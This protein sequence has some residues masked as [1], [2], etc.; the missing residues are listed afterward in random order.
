[1]KSEKSFFPT[2]LLSAVITFVTSVCIGFNASSIFASTLTTLHVFNNAQGGAPAGEL[3]SDGQGNLYGTTT[4]G[5]EFSRGT[6]FKIPGGTTATPGALI[7]L[8]SFNGAGNGEVPEGAMIADAFGNLYGVTKSGGTSTVGSAYGD[9]TIFKLPG[10]TTANPGTITTFATFNHVNG[11][12]PTR[13][14]AADAAGNFYGATTFGGEIGWGTVFKVS[15]SAG[16]TPGTITTLASFGFNSG[17]FP[18]GGV[19]ING[20]GDIY[21]TTPYGGAN[22]SGSGS[23]YRISG[24]ATPV[25]QPL[26]TIATFAGSNGAEPHTSLTMDRL[27]NLYGVT[28]AGASNGNNGFGWGTVFKIQGGAGPNPGAFT[29]LAVF[30]GT[31]GGKPECQLIID[32]SGTI[33]G[34]TSEGGANGKGTIFKIANAISGSPSPLTTLFSFGGDNG[35]RPVAGLLPDARGNLYGTTWQ[36]GFVGYGTV[37][38]LSDTGYIG[39]VGDSNGDYLVDFNDLLALAQNY[40][41][42]SGATW[43]QG[44]FDLDGSVGF[45]DLLLLAQ[46]FGSGS[47]LGSIAIGTSQLQSDWQLARSLVPEPSIFG[48]VAL[49]V[50]SVAQRRRR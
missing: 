2:V 41:S 13:G 19:V 30:D 24:G 6:I 14:L 8:G 34:T 23:I 1:M 18:D 40:Q 12:R 45:N 17:R 5:G 42:P 27:G 4:G 50:V 39:L 29:T 10:G 37:F 25:A 43:A 11:E 33:F 20:A 15:N 44:D 21:G 22:G 26:E 47:Q 16:N 9:G 3:I 46:Y 38:K 36:S 35:V 28:N 32:E 48:V 31:N 7:V 49:T